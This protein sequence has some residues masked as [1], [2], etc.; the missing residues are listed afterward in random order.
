M[1]KV[2]IRAAC[3]ILKYI[4]GQPQA[5][6]TAVGIAKYWIFQQRLE[7]NLD[8][9]MVAIDFLLEEGILEQVE[10]EDGGFYFRANQEKIEKI[11][12]VLSRLQLKID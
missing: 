5:K 8:I 3:D 1:T 9:V 4:Q 6:H 2:E 12:S 10:K 11:P 7:E